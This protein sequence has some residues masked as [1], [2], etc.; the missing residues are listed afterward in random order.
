MPTV[1]LRNRYAKVIRGPSLQLQH[2]R[3]PPSFFCHSSH[4]SLRRQN[5]LLH[6]WLWDSNKLLRYTNE[7]W[8]PTWEFQWKKWSV[9]ICLFLHAVLTLLL[10][11]LW[12]PLGCSQSPLSFSIG[13]HG[14]AQGH[15]L[16]HRHPSHSSADKY[17][18][19]KGEKKGI[20]WNFSICEVRTAQ[21]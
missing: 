13:G 8:C 9:E 4:P 10:G 5:N 3:S 15:S 7:N 20:I 14:M 19:Y 21:D 16:W 18:R 17:A 11:S 1:L 12:F 6:F 2:C